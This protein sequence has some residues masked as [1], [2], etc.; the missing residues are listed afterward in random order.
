MRLFAKDYKA[1]LKVARKLS[2]FYDGK[3]TIVD[4]ANKITRFEKTG[5]RLVRL[6]YLA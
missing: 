4:K 5:D 3:I 6:P 1:A 2:P